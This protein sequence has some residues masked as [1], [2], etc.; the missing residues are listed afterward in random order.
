LGEHSSAQE[1]CARGIAFSPN[2]HSVWTVR[3]MI[4]YPDP[5][6]VSDFQEAV[7]LGSGSYSPYFHLAHDA[8][9]RGNYRE[10][11]FW[12]EKT[13]SCQPDKKNKAILLAWL[14]ISYHELGEEKELV[15]AL[16]AES[17]SL[18]PDNENIRQ[19]FA[20]SQYRF[21]GQE[22]FSVSRV[23][24]RWSNESILTLD[25]FQTSA[26]RET[27]DLIHLGLSPSRN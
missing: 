6:A 15:K 23:E 19:A 2:S 18:D 22:R 10:V 5:R 20:E 12:V 27:T 9:A 17:A 25:R 14:A 26:R 7:R 21:A 24:P 16:F 1:V 8:L 11:R 3:G 13:I 4:T